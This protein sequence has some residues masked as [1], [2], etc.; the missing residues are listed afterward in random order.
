MKRLVLIGLM[1]ISTL[2]F[3][4]NKTEEDKKAVYEAIQQQL[5]E[6]TIDI[7]TAQQMWY[8]YIRCCEKKEEAK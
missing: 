1:L 3:A 6:G 8:T 7:K 5:E 2:S 4:H